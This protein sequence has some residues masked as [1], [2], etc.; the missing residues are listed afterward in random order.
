MLLGRLITDDQ[1]GSWTPDEEASLIRAMQTQ[2]ERNKNPGNTSDF[3]KQVS[4]MLG[5]T[6]TPDQCR[7]K[8]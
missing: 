2:A 7:N 5:Q 3:W 6:R 8:W 1:L 4:N